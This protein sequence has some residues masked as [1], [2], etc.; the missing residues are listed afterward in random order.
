MPPIDVSHAHGILQLAEALR[1][2]GAV[3][4]KHV[5]FFQPVAALRNAAD[6]SSDPDIGRPWALT[7][8]TILDVSLIA[9]DG[10]R[11]SMDWVLRTSP[12]L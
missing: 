9:L 11:S 2:G 5:A 6:H 10:V 1:A 12:S 3:A 7:P 8:H 4:A